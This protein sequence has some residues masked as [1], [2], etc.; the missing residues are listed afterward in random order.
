MVSIVPYSLALDLAT[1]AVDFDTHSFKIMLL[2]ASYTPNKAHS[3]RSD[4]TNQ[5]S[6]TGY[7]AG[8]QAITVAS[9]TRS[10]GT[11][12]VAWNTVTWSS[13]NSFSAAYGAIYR[14]R[15]GAASADELVAVL[16]F[17]G[18]VAASGGNYVLTV[19]TPLRIV[20]P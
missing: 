19:S 10:T 7:T 12:S 3:K 17:G 1:G 9:V 15:G 5:V 4:L 2:T 11:T 13:A 6:G 16:D 8:G 14:D 18:A 20:V